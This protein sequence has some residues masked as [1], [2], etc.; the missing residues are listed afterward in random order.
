MKIQV[1]DDLQHELNRLFIA[2]SKFSNGD[3]RIAKLIPMLHKMGEK[4]PVMK[5]LAEETDKLIKCS[6]EESAVQLAETCGLLYSVLNTQGAIDTARETEDTIIYFNDALPKTILPYSAIKKIKNALT[7][8]NSGRYE[9][10]KKAYDEKLFL[11]DRLKSLFAKG[12]DDKFVAISEL[13]CFDIIPAVGKSMLPY[14]IKGFDMTG[15]KSAA[16]RYSLLANLE[17]DKIEELTEY[18]LSNDASAEVLV[19]VCKYLG[20]DSKNEKELLNLVNHKNADV[21]EAA[22]NSLMNINSESGKQKMM[23]LLSSKKYK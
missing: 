4:A 10:I 15:K 5:K 23:E 3:P 7:T 21:R 20:E 9:V 19:A 6:A 12:L 11:D 18:I 16:M 2:G 22:L 17:Y 8:S 14:I 13:M 1:L